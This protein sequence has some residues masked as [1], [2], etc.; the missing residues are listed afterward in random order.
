M[1][2]KCW[3]MSPSERPTFAELRSMFEGLLQGQHATE[4]VDFTTPFVP[5]TDQNRGDDGGM[6]NRAAKGTRIILVLVICN[7]LV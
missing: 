5:I 6:K 4:Y 1:M 3:E 2:Y 7:V